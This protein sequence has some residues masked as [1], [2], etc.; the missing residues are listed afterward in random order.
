MMINVKGTDLLADLNDA[1]TILSMQKRAYIQEV[2]LN[3]NNFNIPD[4]SDH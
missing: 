2:E 3:D 4:A 1:S